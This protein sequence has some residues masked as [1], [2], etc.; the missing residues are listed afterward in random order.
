[1]GLRYG[2]SAVGLAGTIRRAF[3]KHPLGTPLATIATAA[4]AFAFILPQLTSAN[5]HGT[6]AHAPLTFVLVF[7]GIAGICGIVMLPFG[8]V[9]VIRKHQNPIVLTCP[10][11][12][13]ESRAM[14]TPFHVERLGDLDYA[15]VTCSQCGN[16]FTVPGDARLV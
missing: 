11:C 9:K 5:G 14:E 8:L 16:D 3:N 6:A 15:Y 10:K 7:F 4:I 12:H 1:M 2:S 13:I